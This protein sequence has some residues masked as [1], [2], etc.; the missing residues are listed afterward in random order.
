MFKECQSIRAQQK[1][2]LAKPTTEIRE[3]AVEKKYTDYVEKKVRKKT[4]ETPVAAPGWEDVIR[5]QIDQQNETVQKAI[6]AK[7]N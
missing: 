2:L 3:R 5:K 4:I 6:I 7:K 1:E